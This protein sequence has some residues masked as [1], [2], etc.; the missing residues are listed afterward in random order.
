MKSIIVSVL[1]LLNMSNL[2]FAYDL[3]EGESCMY[4][5]EYFQKIQINSDSIDSAKNL[6]IDVTSLE[7]NDFE[8][9]LSVNKYFEPF[10]IIGAKISD[11]LSAFSLSDLSKGIGANI[12]MSESV[13]CYAKYSS[14][15]IVDARLVGI[16]SSAIYV[17]V[18]YNF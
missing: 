5:S 16:D 8:V 14:S 4:D 9:K 10:I 11:F 7:N 17:G 15:T 13:S 12:H 18:E 2:L 6:F 3:S 1:I